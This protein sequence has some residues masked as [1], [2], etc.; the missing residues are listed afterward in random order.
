M[1][2]LGLCGPLLTTCRPLT[3]LLSCNG[4]GSGLV[5][6]AEW[7][8]ISTG[9]ALWLVNDSTCGRLAS[10]V[11]S[12]P[13]SSSRV[14][15]SMKLTP[16]PVIV[17]LKS[18]SLSLLALVWTVNDAVRGAGHEAGGAPRGGVQKG[19]NDRFCGG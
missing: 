5:Q 19:K 2:W 4:R 16:A 15:D 1:I 10:P 8:R 11:A 6:F 9:C 12:A 17:T 7:G 13:K 18:G 14:E 3:S